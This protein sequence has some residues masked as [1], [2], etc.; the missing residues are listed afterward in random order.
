MGRG[1]HAFGRV[2]RRRGQRIRP[3]TLAGRSGARR[4]TAARRA[5]RQ[6]VLPARRLRSAARRRSA[7]ARRAPGA[8]ARRGGR[9]GPVDAQSCRRHRGPWRQARRRRPALRRQRSGA[10]RIRDGGLSRCDREPLHADR[11]VAANNNM[12]LFHALQGEY[13]NPARD[14]VDMAEASARAKFLEP[15]ITWL[16]NPVGKSL[17]SASASWFHPYAARMCDLSAHAQLVRAQLEIGAA[18]VPSSE[19]PR[20]LAALRSSP[21]RSRGTRSGGRQAL[22]CCGSRRT[23]IAGSAPKATWSPRC[24]LRR[25]ELVTPTLVR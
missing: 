5:R 1:S 25:T 14:C 2:R 17:I 3:G 12:A 24:R 11:R 18:S 8:R 21:I 23:I 15:D 16:Y 19:V 10:L 4:F 7:R 9:A 22:A 13:A 20:Y 6:R